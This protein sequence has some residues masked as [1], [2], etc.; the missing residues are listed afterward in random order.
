MNSFLTEQSVQYYN[1]F[2]NQLKVI[3]PDDNLT[4]FFDN[5][6]SLSDEDKLLYCKKFNESFNDVNFDLFLKNKIKVFS[7]KVE[8]NMIISETLLGK[9][10]SL[11]NILNNQPEQVKN[12]IWKNLHSMYIVG[13][14]QKP[15]DLQNMER[16]KLLSTTDSKSIDSKSGNR[17]QLYDILNVDVNQDTT[18]MIDDIVK[19]FE[20]ILTKPN[21]NPLSSVMEISKMISMKYV[22]KIN[23]GEIELNKLME[24]IMKKMPGMDK[25]MAEM[26]GAGGMEKMMEK[27]MGG[28]MGGMSK[29]EGKKKKVIIDENFSTA[30]VSVPKIKEDSSNFKLG[31]ALKI[32]D[33]FG[34]LPRGKEKTN[35][36]GESNSLAGLGGLGDMFKNLTSGGKSDG[37]LEGLGGLG[38]MFKNLTSSINS[39]GNSDASLQ[40]NKMM[41]M[42]SKMNTISSEEDASKLKEEMD[43][44]LEKDL[45]V[46]IKDI[47]NMMNNIPVEKS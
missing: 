19:S 24:S 10:L 38:D 43:S 29:K 46:N 5:C 40:L 35:N 42:L 45:G 32:A 39:D 41:G 28:M 7:H 44:F 11:K 31:S 33:Q 4:N 16:I 3:F 8:E 27:M 34:I 13:E 15:I 14:I 20:D 22:D 21:A 37:N 18:M 26:G 23:K 1:N 30:D 2:I 12:I 9:E 36:S 47:S 17:H 25:V 6:L